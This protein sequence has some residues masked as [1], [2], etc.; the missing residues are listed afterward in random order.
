MFK[1]SKCWLACFR[2]SPGSQPWQYGHRNLRWTRLRLHRYP[3]RHLRQVQVHKRFS[4]FRLQLVDPESNCCLNDLVMKAGSYLVDIGGPDYSNL[5]SVTEIYKVFICSFLLLRNKSISVKATAIQFP[6]GKKG[7]PRHYTLLRRLWIH[8]PN[9][10][11][12]WIKRAWEF[13]GN[14]SGKGA[15]RSWQWK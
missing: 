10:V 12:H 6:E 14:A 2:D 4:S 13:R 15:H 7:V 3:Q 9:G 5:H 1:S 11:A 8:R